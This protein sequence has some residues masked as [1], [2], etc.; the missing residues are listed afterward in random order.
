MTL[1][2]KNGYMFKAVFSNT[3]SEVSWL[4]PGQIDMQLERG[5]H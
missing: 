1:S 4:K 3:H 2:K 5:Y